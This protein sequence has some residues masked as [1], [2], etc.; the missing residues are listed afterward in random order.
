MSS[1]RVMIVLN[2]LSCTVEN[3]TSELSSNTSISNTVLKSGWNLD[4]PSIFRIVVICIGVVGCLANG[5]VLRALFSKS[6]R[7]SNTNVL[8]TNQ[9]IADLTC[10]VLLICTNA[11]KLP[12]PVYQ[13]TWGSIVCVL[14]GSEMLV[15]MALNASFAC[16]AFIT[17]ER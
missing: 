5:F 11:I 16:L 8:I 14:F 15:W 6:L 1:T 4:L 10:C 2:T 17:L 13:G 7:K 3:D 12:K 9:S